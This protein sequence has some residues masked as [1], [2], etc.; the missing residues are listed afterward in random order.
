VSDGINGFL[1]TAEDQWRQA[2]RKL[3]AD[4]DLRRRMGER[5]R[6]LVKTAY[7]LDSQAPRLIEVL[8][9]AAGG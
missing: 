4:P 6:E 8:Y 7:S 3:I 1:A 2:L 5:G 9:N